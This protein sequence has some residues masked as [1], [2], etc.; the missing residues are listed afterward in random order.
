M[1]TVNWNASNKSA[2]VRIWEFPSKSNPNRPPWVSRL[3][4]DGSTSCN[5]PGW[6]KHVDDNGHRHCRHIETV[7]QEIAKFITSPKTGPVP[8]SKPKPVPKPADVPARLTIPVVR[9]VQW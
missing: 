8:K 3:Y 9:K 5:C 7:E 4:T 2:V 1:N 6:T